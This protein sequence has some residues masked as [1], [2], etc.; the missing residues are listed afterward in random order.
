[1]GILSLK[2]HNSH[3][4]LLSMLFKRSYKETQVLLSDFEDCRKG[5]TS[6]QEERN[7]PIDLN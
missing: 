7:G 6:L 3:R 1:M 5:T 4:T 2:E